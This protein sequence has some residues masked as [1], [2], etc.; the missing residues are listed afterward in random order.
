MTRG[1][2]RTRP[3]AHSS[4]V[5]RHC[6][7]LLCNSMVDIHCH[8]LPALDDG[9]VE[10]SVA[11]R[12]AAMAAADGI[13]HIVATPHSNYRYSFDP[14][15]NRRK[16]DELQQ[17]IGD[18]LTLLLGC[19]FHLSYENLEAVRS[20]P[21]CFT[22]NGLQYLLVEFADMSIPP[23]MDQIFFDL[24]SHRLVPIVTHP[25]R[26]PLLSHDLELIRKWIELGCLV[27][28]TAGSF[29]GR[30]GKR[31]HESAFQLLRNQMVHFIASDAHNT[32]S[33]P[34]LL[35]EARK[36]IAAELG[37]EVAAA[38]SEKNPQ[39][40]VEGQRLPWLPAPQAAAPPRRWFSFR[41]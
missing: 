35:S 22:I 8:I 13:T 4:L 20:D 28:I 6:F 29:L 18:S 3:A 23:S 36:T 25:E 31:A 19:D 26:N 2:S 32:S 10:S 15:V 33:R 14:E 37:E 9:A 38:L 12:M 17:Q 5:T 24:I 7:S 34:P 41:R 16:R 27:Q 39:A 1:V 21:A 40:A 11:Q 30:F